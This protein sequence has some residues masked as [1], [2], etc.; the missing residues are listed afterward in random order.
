MGLIKGAP[1]ESMTRV[2]ARVGVIVQ[3]RSVEFLC[4]V[5]GGVDAALLSA[6]RS[7][8][9]IG[10]FHEGP[11]K[12]TVRDYTTGTSQY[13]VLEAAAAEPTSAVLRRWYRVH[14][15]PSRP[16]YA[17]SRSA[18]IDAFA[19]LLVDHIAAKIEAPI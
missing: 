2:T 14:I 7:C 10:I 16:D 15:A 11:V 5:S 4:S 3:R 9:R 8:D 1:A 18:V 17:A 19:D 13:W 6:G 12:L